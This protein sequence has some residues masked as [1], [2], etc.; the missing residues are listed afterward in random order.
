MQPARIL[1][2]FSGIGALDRAVEIVTGGQTCQ[3]VEADPY[4]RAVLAKHWPGVRRHSDVREFHTSRGKFDVVCGGFP[5]RDISQLGSRKGLA[6]KHSGLWVEYK[7]IIQE[8]QPHAVFIEN[9]ANLRTRGLPRV[10]QD[11]ADF[12][13]DAAWTC[14]QAREVGRPFKRSR[15]FLLAFSEA[16]RR[17]RLTSTWVRQQSVQQVPNSH[18]R[19]APLPLPTDREGSTTYDGPQP[20]VC[21]AVGRAARGLDARRRRAR[22]GSL[23]DTVVVDQAVAAYR[24]CA[25]QLDLEP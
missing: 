19:D 21:R 12:G 25:E 9:V 17:Q 23:G 24:W 1:S 6:G 11:L 10:L 22:I 16:G 2:L 13:F 4:R 14:S 15:L 3:Q 7:R 18:R 20:G 5:C 8:S